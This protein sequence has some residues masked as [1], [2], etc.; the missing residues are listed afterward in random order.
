MKLSYSNWMQYIYNTLNPKPA[1]KIVY[2]FGEIGNRS[3]KQ[4]QEE[5]TYLKELDK[6]I[7]N[8]VRSTY[9]IKNEY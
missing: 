1:K 7:S 9:S 4:I 6:N 5:I 3:E 8:K 2:Q